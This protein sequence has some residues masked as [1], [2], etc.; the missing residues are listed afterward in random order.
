MKIRIV[1]GFVVLIFLVS[2][3]GLWMYVNSINEKYRF[4]EEAFNQK[5]EELIRV[6]EELEEIKQEE[7]LKDQGE[8]LVALKDSCLAKNIA[9]SCTSYSF[10]DNSGICNSKPIALCCGNRVCE[11]GER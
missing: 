8:N 3:V 4:A 5:Q 10:E 9:G 2:V 7:A 1:F 11:A 6:K